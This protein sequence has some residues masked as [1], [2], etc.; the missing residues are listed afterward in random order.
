MKIDKTEGKLYLYDQAEL[1]YLDTELKSGIIILDYNNNEVTAGRIKDSTGQLTQPPF[2]KQAGNEVNPDSIRFNFDTKKA[3]I[4]NSKSEQNGMNVTAL[5][6][7]KENDSVYFIKD[8]K[9]TTSKNVEDPEYYIRVRKG[10]FIPKNKIIAGL[11][12]LYI[13]DVPT[14]IFLPFA[15]FP[16]TENR[17]TGFI[18]PSIWCYFVVYF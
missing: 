9:V 15:Y 1:Y 14:P 6:T 13:E 10:K 2:F 5:A 4:W 17:K 18:F 7:K 3:I 11:S 12:N 8:A 16:L